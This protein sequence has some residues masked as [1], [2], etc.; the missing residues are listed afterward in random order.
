VAYFVNSGS[1]ANDMA[2]MMARLY[3]GNYDIIALRNAYHGLSAATMGLLGQNTWKFNVPQVCVS[4]AL[5]VR[6]QGFTNA[7]GAT[8]QL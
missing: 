4:R 1:E 3:T 7:L 8:P 6:A 5:G 2:M